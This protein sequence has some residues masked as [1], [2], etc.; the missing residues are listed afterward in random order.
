MSETM[1]VK[2]GAEFRPKESMKS[3]YLIYFFVILLVGFLS[4]ITPI[5]IYVLLFEPEYNL[6]LSLLLLPLLLSSVFVV[7]WIQRYY[8]TV[9]YLLGDREI[10]VTR[11]VWFRSK[12]I[13][14]YNRITNVEI[15]Q[16]PISR[17]FGVGTVSIQTAGYSR[18]S[19]SMGRSAEAEIEFVE[20]FEGL[21]DIV[22]SFIAKSR[23]VAV[24]AEGEAAPERDVESQ[25]LA[26]L[27]KIRK[28][29]EKRSRSRRS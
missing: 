7:Y 9:K 1:D 4:W 15:H 20:D 27:K 24:E 26:E 11:G 10:V 19:S 14:P 6:I 17:R 13:V 21:K 18:P 22:R 12:K 28:A 23:P 29:L 25:M 16:G 5:A 3:I 8:W 2:I